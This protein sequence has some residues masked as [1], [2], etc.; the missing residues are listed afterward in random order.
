MTHWRLDNQFRA[1][2]SSAS[3][4]VKLASRLTAPG[5]IR[6]YRTQMEWNV[7]IFS[8]VVLLFPMSLVRRSRISFAALLVNVTA[9]IED[10]AILWV[11]IKRAI[12]AVRTYAKDK[13]FQKI[14]CYLLTL[15]LPLPGPARICRGIAG[16]C[17]TARRGVIWDHSKEG[18]SLIYL[19]IELD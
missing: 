12:L 17:S 16:S 5:Y 6:R 9:H 14:F 10:G 19:A 1:H 15:V 7:P 18:V 3:Q 4:I 8:S 13:I 11:V 2:L